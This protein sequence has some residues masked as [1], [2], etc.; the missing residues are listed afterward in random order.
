M[1]PLY[2]SF[3]ALGPYLK[4]V[5]IDFE[6]MGDSALFLIAGPT[7]GGK[8][9]ILDAVCFAL[10]CRATGGKRDF[11]SMRCNLAEED[12]LTC[13]DFSF[14]MGNMQYRFERRLVPHVNRNTKEYG[15]KDKHACYKRESWES[16]W[17]LMESGS[18][19]AV[20][21]CAENLLCLSCEQFSQVIV[22]PQGEFLRFLRESSK[23]KGEMLKSLFSAQR[24]E[25]IV[26]IAADR[27]GKLEKQ[28]SEGMT[29][30]QSLLENEGVQTGEA[31][32]EA[33]EKLADS[34]K[35]GEKKAETLTKELAK[36]E[37]V[38]QSGREYIRLQSERESKL[39]ALKAAEKEYSEAKQGMEN[40]KDMQRL[41]EELLKEATVLAQETV[42]LK[43]QQDR[44]LGVIKSR[45]TARE[46]LL[47]AGKQDELAEKTAKDI[48]A[49]NKS[50]K[51]GQEFLNAAREAVEEL[52]GLMQEEARLVRAAEA[53]QELEK[54][55]QEKVHIEK[56]AKKLAKG[57]EN[58]KLTFKSF[59]LQ[60][61]SQN[62]IRRQSSAYVLAQ[63][64]EEN[65][66]C[67]VCGSREHPNHAKAGKEA[68]N[69]T[70]YKKLQEMEKKADRSL[71][72]TRAD[73]ERC[74]ADLEEAS[75]KLKAQAEQCSGLPEKSLE[76]TQEKQ[77]KLKQILEAAQKKVSQIRSAENK[78][79][80]LQEER[81]KKIQERAGYIEV[82]ASLKAAAKALE[83]PHQKESLEK[84]E[85]LYSSLAGEISAGQKKRAVCE[86]K[87]GKLRKEHEAALSRFSGSKASLEAAKTQMDKAEGDFQQVKDS[88]REAPVL[89]GIRQEFD[90]LQKQVKE[91]AELMGEN[92]STFMRMENTYK[93]V[94][95]LDESLESLTN[96]Y[97]VAAKLSESLS[98]KNPYK[99]PI[100]Q[101][102]LSIML[103]EILISANQFFDTLSRGRYALQRVTKQQGG[104]ALRGLDIEVLDGYSMTLRSI[105]TLSGG[106]Q[107]LAS[108][109]LAFGLSDVVQKHSGAVKLDALFID[110]GFGS[111]DTETLDIAMG[112]LALL[113][114]SGRMIGIISHITELRSRIPVRLEVS[115]DSTGSAEVN[116]HL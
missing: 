39:N 46:K 82:S 30:R 16:E 87:A 91:H 65:M 22:L 58:D 74:N 90:R 28:Y 79:N 42:Q 44:L 75:A 98:G 81:D 59:S 107:F 97:K 23:E 37:E 64:L 83:E 24:W 113:R 31:L 3:Q 49:A 53:L 14:G 21:K 99:T 63:S 11:K 68:M 111:L 114:D 69:E 62:E 71:Q 108:L 109:S 36:A 61:E 12:A 66:P 6:S 103:D 115:R 100:L 25:K 35:A 48:E 89:E 19:S 60:L 112:A 38:L 4:P 94:C 2:L 34:I 70:E 32:K 1:K 50:M 27:Q 43:E 8:T 110:E 7:G 5:E 17:S 105:E 86:T 41:Q 72:K 102:V 73:M 57:F 106:E 26:R 52:P 29:K 15:L 101:Y 33:A 56:L 95:S 10:Y 80:R 76:E 96:S 47:E 54:R 51:N 116:L 45:K 40:G 20:R 78:M 84:Q 88:W 18:E 67:P 13:V 55:K 9:S 77:N 104:S 93:T 92:R 85:L